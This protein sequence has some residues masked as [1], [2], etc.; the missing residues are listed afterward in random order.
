MS[1]GMFIRGNLYIELRDPRGGRILARRARNT[2]VR[3]GASLIADLFAGVLTTPV[4]GM[5]VGTSGQPL[6]APYELAALTTVDDT[7]QP[8]SGATAVAI[9]PADI[10]TETLEDEQRILVSIR[11]VLP[12]TAALSHAGATSF[13][14]E[15]ALGILSADTTTAPSLARIYNRVVFD[16]IPKGP[17]HELALYWEI[18]FPYGV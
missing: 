14:S 3:S 8:L 2:V 6:S 1:D 13:L 12:K 5:G 17:E 18:S 7:G 9:A 11:G 10:K 4:N 16:P 15:A